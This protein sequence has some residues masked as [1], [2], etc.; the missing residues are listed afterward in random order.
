MAAI[1]EAREEL[2][3]DRLESRNPATGEV[4]G[5]VP[6]FGDKDVSEAVDRAR[7]ASRLWGQLSFSRRRDELIGFRRE[8]AKRA[9]E[10]ADLIHRENGKPRTEA[11]SEVL[12]TV[13]HLDHAAKRAE[14]VLGHA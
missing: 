14:A 13:T 7:A 5:S 3:A 10:L 2:A 8:L 12:L 6:V 9:D 11:I 1:S 4:L